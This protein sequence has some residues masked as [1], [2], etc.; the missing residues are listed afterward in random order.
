MSV[1][2]KMPPQ[3]AVQAYYK[4]GS[5]SRDLA[6]RPFAGGDQQYTIPAVAAVAYCSP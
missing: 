6:Q 5:V 4:T 2:T 1:P 3:L